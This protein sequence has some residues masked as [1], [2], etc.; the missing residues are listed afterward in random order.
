MQSRNRSLAVPLRKSVTSSQGRCLKPKELGRYRLVFRPA[1]QK[2][3]LSPSENSSAFCNQ[4][5]GELNQQLQFSTTVPDLLSCSPSSFSPLWFPRRISQN[6][7]ITSVS[8]SPLPH[9]PTAHT[10][11]SRKPCFYQPAPCAWP[12]EAATLARLKVRRNR[13]GVFVCPAPRFLAHH[14]PLP[15]ATVRPLLFAAVDRSQSS[16]LQAPSDLRG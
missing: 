1:A 5:C 2:A 3:L 15:K 7:E 4:L 11:T 12:A 14:L 13:D 16:S 8:S 9:L 10:L 6:V